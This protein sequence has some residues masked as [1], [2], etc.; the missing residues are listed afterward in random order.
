MGFPTLGFVGF[1]F[2]SVPY[3]V[4]RDPGAVRQ[5]GMLG[6][7]MCSALNFRGLFC[8]SPLCP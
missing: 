1:F 4:M 8:S 2:N 5:R 3:K 6:R 7:G